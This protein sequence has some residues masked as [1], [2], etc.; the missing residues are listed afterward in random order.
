VSID[1]PKR[2]GASRLAW[3]SLVASCV[4]WF[5]VPFG[6]LLVAWAFF[7]AAII[8]FTNLRDGRPVPRVAYAT[9]IISVLPWLC[10]TVHRDMR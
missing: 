9:L 1:E 4:G 8:V 7:V 6:L 3:V 2:A 5:A 10:S